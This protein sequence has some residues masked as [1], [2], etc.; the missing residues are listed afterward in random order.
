MEWQCLTCKNSWG[1]CGDRFIEIRRL[2]GA[3]KA[4]YAEID[5]LLVRTS[6]GLTRHRVE[7]ERPSALAAE[8]LDLPWRCR[9][10]RFETIRLLPTA[11]A[12]DESTA[13][14]V[15]KIWEK[16]ARRP[17]TAGCSASTAGLVAAASGFFRPWVRRR[18]FGILPVCGV[19][20]TAGCA[21]HS[22]NWRMRRCGTLLDLQSLS[23]STCVWPMAPSAR[24]TPS[25][26]FG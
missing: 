11:W 3:S 15:M 4:T 18:S 21:A 5:D 14:P 13:W 10:P 16:T 25:S 17:T 19:C 24:G 12:I 7:A 2:R 9:R 23:A 20:D 22:Y 1:R 6:R 8:P 26:R